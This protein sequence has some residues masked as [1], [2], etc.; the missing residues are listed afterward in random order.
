MIVLPVGIN[1]AT[2]VAAA[3]KELGLSPRQA[4]AVGDAE[5]DGPLLELCGLAVAVN[6][7]Q[8]TADY[9]GRPAPRQ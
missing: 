2:G 8:Q 7:S 1:K 4:V 3:L 6:R 5:N 9:A